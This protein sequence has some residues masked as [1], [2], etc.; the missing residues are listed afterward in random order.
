M[1]KKANRTWE[2]KHNLK[3]IPTNTS[4]CTVRLES[5]MTSGQ[6]LANY[7]RVKK[8][9]SFHCKSL[10]S[11]YTLFYSATPKHALILDHIPKN[12]LTHVVLQD[13]FQQTAPMFPL[14]LLRQFVALPSPV[15]NHQK[16]PPGPLH[17]K[18]EGKK[19]Q[20][21]PPKW[22]IQFLISKGQSYWWSRKVRIGL[23]T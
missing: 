10:H 13:M 2:Q 16:K 6:I 22:R 17:A 19:N 14:E 20:K 9:P 1:Q 3:V 11:F 8:I 4:A 7:V 15:A 23:A 18:I 5:S 21:N 12:T